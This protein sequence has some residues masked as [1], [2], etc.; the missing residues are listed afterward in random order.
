MRVIYRGKTYEVAY[1]DYFGIDSGLYGLRS[2]FPH[3][4]N[5][6][7]MKSDCRPVKEESAQGQ[8]EDESFSWLPDG[9]ARS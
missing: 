1:A 3:G 5:F 9:Q 2:R 8:D 7:A 6:P 4:S